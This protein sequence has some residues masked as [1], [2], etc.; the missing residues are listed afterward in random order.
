MA[1]G[2]VIN[3]ELAAGVPPSDRDSLIAHA[4][5]PPMSSSAPALR[6]L[7]LLPLVTLQSPC[8]YPGPGC[9]R[10][11]PTFLSLPTQKKAGL[12]Y[13]TEGTGEPNLRPGNILSPSASRLA[14]PV[15]TITH[16][17]GVHQ[18]R[19]TCQFLG[20]SPGNPCPNPALST[21]TSYAQSPTEQL[22]P[23]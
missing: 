21:A 22:S 2:S 12:T 16:C 18:L 3:D 13:N 1:A 8:N 20:H 9:P 19:R 7:L 17:L 4:F 23:D 11:R 14:F 10:A 5:Q 15:W 6:L